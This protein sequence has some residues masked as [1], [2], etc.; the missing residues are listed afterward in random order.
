MQSQ[1]HP[2]PGGCPQGDELGQLLF[3]VLVSDAGMD[4]APP[5]PSPAFCGDVGSV[6]GPPPP[7]MN[8]NEVR[9]KFID[10]LTLAEAVSLVKLEVLDPV[11]GPPTYHERNG[12][13]L[14]PESSRVHRVE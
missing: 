1:P 13:A 10:D 14:P 3:L 11:I 6:E 9:L 12:V 5:P 7:L 2:L 8:D 4:P